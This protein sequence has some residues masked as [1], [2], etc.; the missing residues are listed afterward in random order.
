M[1]HTLDQPTC[2]GRLGQVLKHG[3]S[4]VIKNLLSSAN[5]KRCMDTVDAQGKSVASR[6]KP[7]EFG[8]LDENVVRACIADLDLHLQADG[9]VAGRKIGQCFLIKMGGA[10][11]SDRKS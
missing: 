8:D 6:G 11:F 3:T 4:L 1:L 9:A 10:H 7:V 2:L 5:L